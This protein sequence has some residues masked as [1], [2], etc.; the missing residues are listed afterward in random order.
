[1]IE[2]LSNKRNI[3]ELA[4]L[5]FLFF[6]SAQASAATVTDPLNQQTSSSQPAVSANQTT[7]LPTQT[8]PAP[9]QST[10]AQTAL[11]P[12]S[13]SSAKVQLN[14]ATQATVTSPMSIKTDTQGIQY[15][16]TSNRDGGK[17]TFTVNVT[18]AGTYVIWGK[19]LSPNANTDSF[20]VS[21]DGG[22]EDV[23]DTAEGKWSSQWQWTTVN[24][25]GGT[26]TPG[27]IPQ[28]Q[29]QLT[30][31]THTITIR[32][33]DAGTGLSDILITD[34]LNYVP[35]QNNP[36]TANAVSGS[37]N[38]DATFDLPLDGKDLDGDALTVSYSQPA[39]GKILQT[40]DPTTGVT[41]YTYTP[42]ANYNGTD[43]FT[44]T[45]SDGT[46]SSQPVTVTLNVNAVNDTPVANDQTVTATK[47]TPLTITLTGSDVDGDT[48]TYLMFRNPRS[49]T[50]SINGNIVTYTPSANFVG[51]DTF[52]FKVKDPSG[53]V[54]Y[55]GRITVNVQNPVGTNV[56][57]VAAAQAVTMNEDNTKTITLQATDADGD[58]MTYAISGQA[59][60]GTVVLQGNIATF[61]PSANY[62]GTDSFSF[63]AID[64]HNNVSNVA[65]VSFTINAVNDAPVAAG[66]TASTT[67]NTA[68][69]ILLSGTDVDG[70]PLTYVIAGNPQHGT[71]SLQGN[72][73]LYTP[74]QNYTGT[75]TF[76]FF[77]R[78]LSGVNSNTAAV[79]FTISN[80]NVAP[81]AAAQSLT[82]SEDNVQMITLQGTDADG[83]PL[84]YA[85]S[86]QPQ[87]GTIVLNN[88]IATYTPN[89]NYN[90]T[91]TFT[92]QAVDTSG[93]LSN[94][95]TVDLTLNPVNDAPTPIDQNLKAH[96]TGT[97]T[98]ILTA[99]DP[100]MDLVRFQLAGNPQNG[101]V[102]L[103]GRTVTYTPNAGFVGTD[104]FTFQGTDSNGAVS[105]TVGTINLDIS[106]VN[107]APVVNNQT[108]STAEDTVGRI[109]VTGT[110]AEGD[111]LTYSIVSQP[112][113]GTISISGSQMAY[114]ADPNYNGTDVFT[115]KAT[116]PFTGVS[117]VATVSL[118]ITPVNDAPVINTIPG[119]SMNA[120]QSFALTIG[121]SDA[122]GDVIANLVVTGLPSFAVFTNNQN[123]TGTLTL[124]P[125][126]SD[127]GIY[128]LNI[129]GTD[130]FGAATNKTLMLSVDP[131]GTVA[132]DP[133]TNYLRQ[134]ATWSNATG[135]TI[136]ANG[137][138]TKTGTTPGWNAAAL[139]NEHI[140]YGFGGYVEFTVTET[141]TRRMIGLGY[142][143]TSV[144]NNDIKF[145]IQLGNNGSYNVIMMNP[146]FGNQTVG[147]VGTYA[148]G[149]I[150][151]VAL[152]PISQNNQ[153]VPH[154]QYSVNYYQNGKLI[155]SQNLDTLTFSALNL[156]GPLYADTS[157]YDAGATIGNVIISAPPAWQPTK[158]VYVS[159]NGSIYGDGT[160]AKPFDLHTVLSGNIP[161]QP[162]TTLYLQGGTYKGEYEVN[163]QG[164]Q[165][166]QIVIKPAPGE[167]VTIDGSIY[168]PNRLASNN[169]PYTKANFVTV[170]GLEVM[171][172][173]WPFGRDWSNPNGPAPGVQYQS[174]N[175]YFPHSGVTV[176]GGDGIKIVNN[177]IHDT[178]EGIEA[179]QT[180]LNTEIYGNIIYQNG[181][182]LPDRAHGHGIY[183]Q[184][185]IGTKV[186]ES[187][188][189]F[190]NFEI[191]LQAY[192]VQGPI[193]NLDFIKNIFIADRFIIGGKTPLD[194][195]N[196]I[197]N[198][199]FGDSIQ[200]GYTALHNVNTRITGNYADGLEIHKFDDGGLSVT[201]NTLF[202][203]AN[204]HQGFE[205][206]TVW[207]PNNPNPNFSLSTWDSNT[208]YAGGSGR[209][210]F[211]LNGP[212]T[213]SAW[214]SR[215]GYD[216]NSTQH[217]GF[218]P[219]TMFIEANKFEPG[220][221]NIA[222]YNWSKAATVQVD[223]SNLGYQIGDTYVLHNAQDYFG[224]TITGV[225]NG[226][227]ITV[228][229]TASSWNA[230]TP[231][232]SNHHNAGWINSFPTF[233][234]FVIEKQVLPAS[235]GKISG[236]TSTSS[237]SSAASVFDPTQCN[238]K[239]FKSSNP[240][241]CG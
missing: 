149:D 140:D 1:M 137:V 236:N 147:N 161:I 162:G 121:T 145:G 166:N 229:M 218:P 37:L 5:T 239:T 100:E 41:K 32:G 67:K 36:P 85:L 6:G 116:D 180:A 217:G 125:T 156:S 232:G 111:T 175:S 170:E 173:N 30:A 204:N 26:S 79:N 129:T 12:A 177:V 179:W 53:A 139:S 55:R 15:I 172:S 233:G 31:G 24:G 38:E 132:S 191:G 42:N 168:F 81:V 78:D 63:T 157:F 18:T 82:L 171:S 150:F 184:N 22:A 209:V 185:A 199:T 154:M 57:P 8:S 194:N 203:S 183:I 210:D 45:V 104:S 208:Y 80:S 198:Y 66:Q 94:A 163:L 144:S 238:D 241:L 35:G 202:N 64:S 40:V 134:S 220:R 126:A 77:A 136:G 27:S 106:T 231:I 20:Y 196:V 43:T 25:R 195:I 151:R 123:G 160:Q 117:N 105:S 131:A 107:S 189:V 68:Q 10:S 118:T 224:G 92:F 169:N 113:H 205:V 110:D 46:I 201:G 138:M 4:L 59:Q 95:A 187:N 74:N 237:A 211:D 14:A 88:N 16:S 76:T 148:T 143:N 214:Q 3:K 114:D 93:A 99:T 108:L 65:V 58:P 112:R 34:N 109:D 235:T 135:V 19:V 234:A 141:N 50:F 223:I 61:T 90:G 49:G 28:R 103:V 230:P 70:D 89:Q 71:V 197:S 73:A 115:Y 75:D 186:T 165:G 164:S 84:T 226:S 133:I 98:I 207:D 33:R 174:I 97:R 7:S 240:A 127:A 120:G 48:L 83:D 130:P 9:M 87:H 213:F 153:N 167:H 2:R 122:D 91:D 11:S 52:T 124:N 62:N 181:Y 29:F 206:L 216:L 192:G 101:T 159:A 56:P 178:A 21:V 54:S 225:Y 119:F 228:S 219:D 60:N 200:V 39:N 142:G 221:A 155:Y 190:D 102:T 128:S 86:T 212:V 215:T 222:V 51:T 13:S 193:K 158:S 17:A 176:M 72:S 152:E 146:N 23:Y 47:N 44:Y 182:V 188:I 96:A 69:T 227:P